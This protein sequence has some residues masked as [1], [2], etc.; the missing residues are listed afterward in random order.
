MHPL[1]LKTRTVITN[2]EAEALI[3]LLLDEVVD[4]LPLLLVRPVRGLGH[5]V[6]RVVA[7]VKIPNPRWVKK[8]RRV[9]TLGRDEITILFSLAHAKIPNPGVGKRCTG[10]EPVRPVMKSPC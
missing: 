8:L 6:R 4:V 1:D 2:K 9:N 3:I 5:R 10:R 7:V